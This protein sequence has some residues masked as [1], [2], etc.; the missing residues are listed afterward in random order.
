M[1]GLLK[2]MSDQQSVSNFKPDPFE[3]QIGAMIIAHRAGLL[4]LSAAA[5]GAL[6][7]ASTDFLWYSDRLTKLSGQL[8]SWDA[9]SKNERTSPEVFFQ[10]AE[11]IGHTQS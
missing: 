4:A 11:F 2:S 5:Q 8:P 6:A 9:S 7:E 1:C 10:S 3:M